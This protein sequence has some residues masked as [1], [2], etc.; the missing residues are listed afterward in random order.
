MSKLEQVKEYTGNDLENIFFRPMLTGP[1]A[2]ELGIKIMYNMPVPT[3]LNFWKRSGDILQKYSASGWN[4][5]ASAEKYQKT[6]NLAKVKAE[7]GYS[8][9]DY[10][11]MVYENITG[12]SEVNLQDL[13]GTEL[14][15]AE[16][17]LFKEA[18][19]ESIRATMWLGDTERSDEDGGINTFDGFIKQISSELEDEANEIN[20]VAISK[21]DSVVLAE[22]LLKSLWN[23]SS[24]ALKEFKTQGNLVYLV[25]SDIYAAYE[26]ELDAVAVESAYLSKQNG[27]DALCYRGIP[28][29]DVRLT[30][31]LGNLEDMPSSFAILTDKRNLAVAVNTNDFPG[32]E[33]RMWYNP[34]EMEN[35]QRAVFMAGCDYLLPELITVAMQEVAFEIVTDVTTSGGDVAVEFSEGLS[36]VDSVS[37]VGLTST[38]AL[39]GESVILT[40]GDTGFDGEI[41]GSSLVSVRVT[42]VYTDGTKVQVIK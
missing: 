40:A 21:S 5:S 32:T 30:D 1:S 7:V 25:T 34:D 37:A 36:L 27:R 8:A 39:A 42:I 29:V 38:G 23:N 3:T 41:E 10:F 22:Q 20:E 16:T 4:G 2:E 12:S 19:S 13:T 9:E 14:E 24:T 11:S 6:L 28:V 15:A 17:Q 33:V 35:R 26:D 31:Y 18:I